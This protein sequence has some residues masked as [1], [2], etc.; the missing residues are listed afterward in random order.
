[1]YIYV[2]IIFYTIVHFLFVFALVS[3]FVILAHTVSYFF[4]SSSKFLFRSFNSVLMSGTELFLVTSLIKTFCSTLF[5]ISVSRLS[6]LCNLALGWRLWL[7]PTLLVE[8]NPLLLTRTVNP[9]ARN[10]K[11]VVWELFQSLLKSMFSLSPN[12]V[13]H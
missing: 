10:H 7:S 8:F 11:S 5:A 2:N 1:M 6:R 3:W 9:R 4:G 12:H 13:I